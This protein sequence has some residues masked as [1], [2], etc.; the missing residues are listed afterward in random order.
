MNLES[1][2]P[3][4]E[5]QSDEKSEALKKEILSFVKKQEPVILA[6]K[7]SEADQFLTYW[8]LL[9]IKI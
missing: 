8:D 4:L 7:K 5:K 2:I 9:K 3:F 6:E 1:L